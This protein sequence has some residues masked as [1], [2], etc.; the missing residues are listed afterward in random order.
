MSITF[1]IFLIILM[2]S[3]NGQDEK[4]DLQIVLLPVQ[5]FNGEIEVIPYHYDYFSLI[6][7]PIFF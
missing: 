1:K 3:V 4:N 5:S 7:I 6:K 2:S